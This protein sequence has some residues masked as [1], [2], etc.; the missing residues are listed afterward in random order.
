LWKN[1]STHAINPD[2][3][4]EAKTAALCDGFF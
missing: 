2:L 1:V 3:F 4:R